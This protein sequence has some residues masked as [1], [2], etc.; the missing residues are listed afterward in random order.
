MIGITN[1]N[2]PISEGTSEHSP[3]LVHCMFETFGC[4]IATWSKFVLPI[5]AN[6]AI[7]KKIQI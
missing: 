3:L 5:L 6:V 2:V 7:S 4:P 1:L